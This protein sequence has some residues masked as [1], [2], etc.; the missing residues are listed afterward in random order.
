MSPMSPMYDQQGCLAS[1]P[2][3]HSESLDKIR[4]HHHIGRYYSFPSF[5]IYEAGQQEEEKEAE[6]SP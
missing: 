6:K 1:S 4:P 3:N 5:D 2:V